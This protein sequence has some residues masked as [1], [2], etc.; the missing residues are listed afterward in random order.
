MQRTEPYHI[1]PVLF[2][3]AK[4]VV[5]VHRQSTTFQTRLPRENTG[6]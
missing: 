3:I 4:K 6:S 2:Y 1:Q 5:R